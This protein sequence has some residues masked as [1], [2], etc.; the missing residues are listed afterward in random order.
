MNIKLTRTNI[1]LSF[2][3]SPDT[4]AAVKTIPGRRWNPTRKI[5]TVPQNPD[6]LKRLIDVL[7]TY[8]TR[9]YGDIDVVRDLASKATAIAAESIEA[10]KA[11]SADF[12][13]EGLGGTLRPFQ[14][15]GVKYATDK[16]RI[17]IGDE[18][19]LG[20]T[21]EAL[22][23]IQSLDAY[24]ALVLCPAS[25]KLN[26]LREARKWLPGKTLRRIS[27]RS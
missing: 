3:Y 11:S 10:S 27:S 16:L 2:P 19:G 13:V 25:L 24:P 7:N 5:W 18:M 9:L 12:E 6:A 26:W 21:I 8:N 20:K 1:E 15:A 17:I 22:A 4:V 23:T 14:K